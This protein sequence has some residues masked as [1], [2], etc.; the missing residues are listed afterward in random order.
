VKRAFVTTLVSVTLSAMQAGAQE[1]PR[2]GELLPHGLTFTRDCYAIRSHIDFYRDFPAVNRGDGTLNAVIEIPA[3]TNA[4]WETDPVTGTL[5]WEFKN[6]APRIIKYLGYVGNYG[7]IPRTV[8][9]DGDPLDVLVI[10]GPLLRGSVVKAKLIGALKVLDGGD[11][12]DKLV[13]VLPGS[14]LYSDSINTLKDLDRE[15]DGITDIIKTWFLNYKGSGEM[16]LDGDGL[17]EAPAAWD[18]LMAAIAGFQGVEPTHERDR[19]PSSLQ[20][21]TQLQ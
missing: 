11:P 17:V 19:S 3:G 1:A 2:C 4:K 12:D 6:G 8:G 13:A 18:I 20:P 14:P 21:G 15:F 5:A 16:V 7:M 9:G 10:G